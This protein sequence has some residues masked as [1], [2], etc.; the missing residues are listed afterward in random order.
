MDLMVKKPAPLLWRNRTSTI[1]ALDLDSLEDDTVLKEEREEKSSGDDGE[2]KDNND[3][4]GK[5]RGRNSIN[6][7]AGLWANMPTSEDFEAL[8]SNIAG[9]E[10]EGKQSKTPASL[11]LPD[12]KA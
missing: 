2:K 1:E 7:I 12:L 6:S 10:L 3:G 4:D 5:R 8:V 11:A 9:E